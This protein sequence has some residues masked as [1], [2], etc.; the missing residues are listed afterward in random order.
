MLGVFTR[1]I[2]PGPRPAENLFMLTLFAI[3]VGIG[4]A[5]VV[6]GVLGGIDA[7]PSRCPYCHTRIAVNHPFRAHPP[8]VVDSWLVC[9]NC[10][11]RVVRWKSSPE[12]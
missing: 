10:R 2:T 11:R 8:L 7:P 1:A 12:L 4:I 6:K 5:V 3:Y 9:D